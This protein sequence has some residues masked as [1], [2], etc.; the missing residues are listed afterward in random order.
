FTGHFPDYPV[1]PGVLV[2]EALAQVAVILAYKSGASSM[3]NGERGIILFAGIDEARFKRQVIPGDV[4]VLEAEM[5]RTTRGVGKYKARALVDGK[6]AC[7]AVLMAALRPPL[8]SAA[9]KKS[10]AAEK[11]K[12]ID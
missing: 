3:P 5:I 8:R 7:E 1:M 2:I 9:Q 10:D 12:V 11:Q 6:V 4:L